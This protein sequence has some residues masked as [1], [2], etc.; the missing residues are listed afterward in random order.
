MKGRKKVEE[1]NRNKE[2]G[3]EIEKNNEYGRY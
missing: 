2:Q 1:K 3:R